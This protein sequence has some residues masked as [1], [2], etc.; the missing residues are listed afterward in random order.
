[1]TSDR[2]TGRL[3]PGEVSWKPWIT[4]GIRWLLSVGDTSRPFK[5]GQAADSTVAPATE[6]CRCSVIRE[7]GMTVH[8]FPN[9]IKIMSDGTGS[10]GG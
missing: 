6:S 4:G 8:G 7:T 5:S 3:R 9:D 1:L 2:E 10:S